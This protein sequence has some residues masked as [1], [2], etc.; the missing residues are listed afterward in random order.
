MVSFQIPWSVCNAVDTPSAWRR[1]GFLLQPWIARSVKDQSPLV[2][3]PQAKTVCPTAKIFDAAF[4][5]LRLRLWQLGHCHPLISRGSLSKTWPQ[6]LHLL[7]EGNQRS[8]PTNVRLCHWHLYSNCLRNSP[9]P[10]S[11]C[12]FPCPHSRINAWRRRGGGRGA[13]NNLIYEPQ[14]LTVWSFSPSPRAPQS[15]IAWANLWLAIMFFTARVSVKTR[16][17]F[18]FMRGCLLGFPQEFIR[19]VRTTFYGVGIPAHAL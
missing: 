4:R 9:Q 7:D 12:A 16:S 17:K 3:S 10:L 2:P 8:I 19:P 18:A 1:E 6:G 14:H 13:L 11:W 5:S 15:A